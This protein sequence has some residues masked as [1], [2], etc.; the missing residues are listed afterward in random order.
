MESCPPPFFRL[1]LFVAEGVEKV[2]EGHVEPFSY[3]FKLVYARIYSSCFDFSQIGSFGSYH[4]GELIE[5]E[6]FLFTKGSYLLAN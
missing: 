1:S 4:K 6:P 5:R 3:A 2:K